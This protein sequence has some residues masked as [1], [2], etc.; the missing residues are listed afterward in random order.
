MDTALLFIGWTISAPLVCGICFI[1]DGD[2]IGATDSKSMRNSM[3]FCTLIVFLPTYFFT[4]GAFE[5]HALWL[6]MTMFMLFRGFTMTYY[7]YKRIPLW[8]S[9]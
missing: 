2:F 5:N 3:L 4:Q 9:R 7:A 8:L 1:W 6:A